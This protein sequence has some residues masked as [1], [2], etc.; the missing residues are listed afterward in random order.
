MASQLSS[1][2][3]TGT[4]CPGISPPEMSTSTVNHNRAGRGASSPRCRGGLEMPTCEKPTDGKGAGHM[5]DGHEKEQ[6]L[7]DTELGVELKVA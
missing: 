3:S 2:S 1:A 6:P 7:V 5:L 4:V